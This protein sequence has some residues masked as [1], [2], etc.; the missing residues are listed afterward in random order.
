M[1]SIGSFARFG[2]F[3]SKSD[4]SDG[5]IMANASSQDAAF[6]LM[7]VSKIAGSE[8]A[9]V[10][11]PHSSPRVKATRFEGPSLLGEDTS[12]ESTFD[13]PTFRLRTVSYTSLD[14]NK[15]PRGIISSATSED[16]LQHL[17][18]GYEPGS[19]TLPTL[20]TLDLSANLQDDSVFQDSSS[21]YESTQKFVGDKIPEGRTVREVLRKKFSWKSYPELEAYLVENRALYL[22]CSHRLNYTAA[23]KQ[24]NN[25]LTQGLLDLAAEVGYVFE[26]FTFAAVRD[27]IRCY[28]KSYVQAV[29]KKKRSRHK[30]PVDT[31][32]VE[33]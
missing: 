24:Y 26:G 8:L 19:S 14:L 11:S 16:S 2:A 4:A 31:H 33:V 29:K 5:R 30:Q 10:V 25:K 15:E 7:Q 17:Q 22:Q 27:R 20:P 28:Y 1:E 32:L 13:T 21:A 12:D 18:L 3:S 6:L 23:Q 9:N